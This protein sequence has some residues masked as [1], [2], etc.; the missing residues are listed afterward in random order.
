MTDEYIE[1]R[2]L[3]LAAQANR[4]S[5]DWHSFLAAEHNKFYDFVGKDLQA[6]SGEQL[7]LD[8]YASDDGKFGV[9]FEDRKTGMKLRHMKPVYDEKNKTLQL[10]EN[11]DLPRYIFGSDKAD[12]YDGR[13]YNVVQHVYGGAGDDSIKTGGG[14]DYLDSGSGRNI[15]EGGTGFDT[16]VLQDDGSPDIIRDEDGQGVIRVGKE[17]VRGAFTNTKE[18][19]DLF[20]SADGRWQLCYGDSEAWE[21]S[22]KGQDGSYR[23]VARLAGWKSGDLGLE[24]MHVAGSDYINAD[25]HQF[26]RFYL[27]ISL[28]GAP[29]GGRIVGSRRN[30]YLTGSEHRDWIET[31]DGATN[32]VFGYGGDDDIRGGTGMDY[33]RAGRQGRLAA[34]QTDNDQVEGG[35]NSDVL[36][37]G[38]GADSLYGGLIGEDIERPGQENQAGDWIAGEEGADHITGSGSRDFLF[39]GSHGDTIRA[40]AGDDLILGDGHY[41]I[42]LQTQTL[43]C[44]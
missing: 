41:Q 13:F 23:V 25:M 9:Y 24:T 40:G 1:D 21:L 14:A 15:L 8:Y 38:A 33:I 43:T 2:A 16:Y 3:F 32:L 7:K 26:D 36:Y 6:A 44:R 10:V 5:K 28:K 20:S 19:P 31:G 27:A 34:G 18:R 37:G 22:Q 12:T 17:A 42:R 35:G 11:T 29:K 39:G 4:V 30:D